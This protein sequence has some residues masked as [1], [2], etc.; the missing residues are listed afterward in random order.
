MTIPLILGL[1]YMVLAAL[2]LSLNLATPWRREIKTAAIIIVSLFYL[3]AYHGAQNLRGWASSDSPPSPFKLHYAVVEEPDKAAGTKGAIYLLAQRIDERGVGIGEPR[4][5]ELPFSPELAEEIDE[6]MAQKE[7]GKDLQAN[8]SYQA[9]NA[10][11]VD[12]IERRDG[13][14]AR[15]DA[16][17]DEERL[18][19]NFRELPTVSLPPKN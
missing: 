5:Y 14:K 8:L 10:E 18:K 9:A 12:E 11:D 3:G 16:M 1:S 2:L 13:K 4:L 17:G 19:L 6:A 7:T 15:P